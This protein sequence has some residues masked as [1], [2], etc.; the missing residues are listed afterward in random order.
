MCWLRRSM[1]CV[2]N[3]VRVGGSGFGWERARLLVGAGFVFRLVSVWR[4][5]GLPQCGVK[6]VE[7]SQRAMEW[8]RV[9][10][11]TDTHRA[12]VH[13]HGGSR[14]RL[15][16]AYQVLGDRESTLSTC[17][18][19]RVPSFMA[20]IVVVCDGLQLNNRGYSVQRSHNAQRACVRQCQ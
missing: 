14:R 7:S 18:R 5:D 17:G 20:N 8:C 11:H 1:V 4:V 15:H 6:S 16:D 3:L 9:T 13:W 19:V 2:M 12:T 10:G